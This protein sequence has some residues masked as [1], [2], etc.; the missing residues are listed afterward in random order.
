M[1]GLQ[2]DLLL[3]RSRAASGQTNTMLVLQSAIARHGKVHSNW[4]TRRQFG[5]SDIEEVL[6]FSCVGPR[7]VCPNRVRRVNRRIRF[8]LVG[9]PVNEQW[10]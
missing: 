4:H 9:G 3:M 7:H 10:R 8:T 2:L 1:L 5:L 6:L